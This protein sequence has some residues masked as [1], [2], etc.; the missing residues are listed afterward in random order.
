MGGTAACNKP[1][2]L[3]LH[4]TAAN[5][6]L[7]TT[8]PVNL[9]ALSSITTCISIAAYQYGYSSIISFRRMV[10][11][12]YS[13]GYKVALDYVSVQIAKS[14]PWMCKQIDAD[15]HKEKEKTRIQ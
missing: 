13:I 7:S 10:K 12:S 2:W 8:P 11:W 1:W 9:I 4:L 14:I 3:T 5:E 6:A 15:I